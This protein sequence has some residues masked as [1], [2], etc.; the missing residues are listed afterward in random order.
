[1]PLDERSGRALVFEE[2]CI[3]I[4]II[5]E[6]KC[7]IRILTWKYFLFFGR[8]AQFFI[9]P[10]FTESGVDR[11]VN[12]VNSEH[13]KNI[14]NDYWRMAQLEK[15]TSNPNHDFSKFETGNKETL[16]IIPKEKGISVRDALL[17]FH[18]KYYSS[19]IMG[20][21]ILGKGK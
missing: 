16:D 17:E 6:K 19:N 20:L 14:Q 5:I 13:E 18:K 12:A 21:S 2:L 11:E 9:S 8:F 3:G 15:S 7:N 1:M 4:I 10:L